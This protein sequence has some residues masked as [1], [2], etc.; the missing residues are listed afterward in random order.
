M[1]DSAYGMPALHC[2]VKLSELVVWL[3][4]PQIKI[5]ALSDEPVDD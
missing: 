4:V 3:I 2:Q 5:Y 1:E